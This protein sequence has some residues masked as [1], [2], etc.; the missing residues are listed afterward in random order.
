M[1]AKKANYEQLAEEV[2]KTESIPA[3]R[4]LTHAEIKR[5][6]NPG[7]RLR[8]AYYGNP[9]R[10]RGLV[11]RV[12]AVRTR[13]RAARDLEPSGANSAPRR[14]TPRA[15]KKQRTAA[16]PAKQNRR[17]LAAELHRVTVAR[18][19][20]SAGDTRALNDL[21]KTLEIFAGS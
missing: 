17:K 10:H 19:P 16:K 12:S 6:D 3:D 5:L 14:S 8:R 9:E 11:L 13:R 18:R 7:V 2:R 15:A 20:L 21:V 1:V 4:E